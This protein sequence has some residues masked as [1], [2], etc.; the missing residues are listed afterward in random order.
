MQSFRP[1]TS[2]KTQ[3]L[4]RPPEVDSIDLKYF[5][6][7]HTFLLKGVTVHMHVRAKNQAMKSKK[8]STDRILLRHGSEEEDKKEKV[9]RSIACS[10]FEE[11]W[12]HPKPLFVDL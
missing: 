9:P 8:L 1:P 11:I 6:E 4:L 5:E 10:I 7:P 12:N 2:K 3:T